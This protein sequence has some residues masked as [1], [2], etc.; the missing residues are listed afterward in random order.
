VDIQQLYEF[1]K[2]VLNERETTVLKVENSILWQDLIK[3]SSS[4]GGK[5]PNAIVAVNKAS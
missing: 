5:R 3:I 1:A 2:Q 4:P